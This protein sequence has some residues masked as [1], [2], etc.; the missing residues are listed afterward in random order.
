MLKLILVVHEEGV[1]CA[2]SVMESVAGVTPTKDYAFAPRTVC[3]TRNVACEILCSPFSRREGVQ[4]VV[5][6]WADFIT[7]LAA[8]EITD[9]RAS[10][11]S[12]N[13]D[14]SSGANGARSM[15][16]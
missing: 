14:F 15:A 7:A 9:V 4:V 2:D 11:T 10:Q 12:A 6:Q 16:S 5:I 1:S 8:K 3:V 13:S